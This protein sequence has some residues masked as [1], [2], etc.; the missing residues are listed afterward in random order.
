MFAGK[1]L[2]AP[3]AMAVLPNGNLIVANTGDNQ[4]IE[5][6]P[7]GQILDQHAVV[8]SKLGYIY[9]LA[10]I[11]TNDANTALYYTNKNTNTVH[12]L[13]Q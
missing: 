8:K 2:N 11:G 4:V 1:P 7:K 10:A 3:S 12:E 13:E 5:M 6:T 9:G